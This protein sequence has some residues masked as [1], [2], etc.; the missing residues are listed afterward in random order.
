MDAA[1]QP[2]V[3]ATGHD[4]GTSVRARLQVDPGAAGPNRFDLTVE[5]YDSGQPLTAD[6]VTLRF[7]LEGRLDVAPAPLDLERDGDARW[8]GSGNVLSI[9]GRW[10]VTALV[11]M[12][13]DAVEVPMELVTRAPAPAAGATTRNDQ[14]CPSAPRHAAYSVA[15]ESSPDPPKAEGTVFRLTVRPDGQPVTGARVCV[16]VNMPDMQHR[17]VTGVA[18]EAGAGRY[19]AD[20]RFSMVGG[21]EGLVVITPADGPAASAPIKVEAT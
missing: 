7:R 13:T 17:G 2:T 4:Y 21:W 12:P 9:D 8:L 10:T 15:V 11:E 16:R 6:A 18:R 20:M 1:R 5:D 14:A 19:D 3:V